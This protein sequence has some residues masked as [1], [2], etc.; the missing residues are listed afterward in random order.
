M[1]KLTLIWIFVYLGSEV[2]SMSKSDTALQVSIWLTS[3]CMA[4]GA[5]HRPWM[6]SPRL[7]SF[8]VSA[9]WQYP[10]LKTESHTRSVTP[11][12]TTTR[13]FLSTTTKRVWLSAST[14]CEHHWQVPQLCMQTTQ[15]SVGVFWSLH[16]K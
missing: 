2:S 14:M 16:Q 5:T 15:I 6:Q 3:K 13:M 7:C 8:R 1:I 4:P 11:G 10:K 9:L 12:S